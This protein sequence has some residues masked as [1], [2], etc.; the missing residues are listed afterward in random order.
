MNALTEKVAIVT[1]AG[2]GIGSAITEAFC[3]EGASVVA[4]DINGRQNALAEKLGDRCVAF[5]ANVA[6]SADVKAMI[7]AAV[8]RFGRLDILVNNAGIDG[9]CAATPDYPEEEFDRVMA[10]NCRSVF[11]G[12]KH[13][14]PEMLKTG[15]GSIVNTASTA[16]VNGFAM[17]PAYCASKGAVVLLT[18]ATAMEFA[19]KGIRVNAICPGLVRTEMTIQVPAAIVKRAIDRTPM[20]RYAEPEEIATTVVFL[21]SD[22]SS[23]ITGAT[24][25]VDGGQSAMGIILS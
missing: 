9:L 11:L 14:I 22:Q 3:G 13:A 21:A 25:M 23:Y 6:Q 17:M 1:G 15:R 8:R 20:A 4:V 24:V 2:G 16:G 12:M 5:H 10:V 19:T 7:Q 18:K